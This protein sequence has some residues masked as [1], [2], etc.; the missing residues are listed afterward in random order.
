MR[1]DSSR[2]WNAPVNIQVLCKSYVCSPPRKSGGR[3]RSRSN[4]EGQRSS[5]HIDGLTRHVAS[6]FRR[7][8]EYHIGNVDRLSQPPEW[9]SSR[10]LLSDLFRRDSSDL[11]V[12]LELVLEHVRINIT[13]THSVHIY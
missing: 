13:G 1:S 9:Y 5:C 3:K 6:L 11:G 7:E 8:E 4:L 10:Q 12:R 2:Y